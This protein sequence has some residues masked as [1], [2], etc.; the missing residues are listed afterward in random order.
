MDMKLQH[1][2][3]VTKSGSLD[4]N[5]YHSFICGTHRSV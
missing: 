4:H 1:L 5:L 2:Y 3:Q